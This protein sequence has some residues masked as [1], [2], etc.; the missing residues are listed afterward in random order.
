MSMTWGA[1]TEFNLNHMSTNPKFLQHCRNLGQNP[2]TICLFIGHTGKEK[3]KKKTLFATYFKWPFNLSPFSLLLQQIFDYIR[4]FHYRHWWK[5]LLFK[6]C[7]VADSSSIK[8]SMISFSHYNFPNSNLIKSK[9]YYDQCRT[10][11]ADEILKIMCNLYCAIYISVYTL[12]FDIQLS[13][14]NALLT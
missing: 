4:S 3:K 10:F 11:L 12:S 9:N 8:Y 6:S 14:N 5:K 1:D 7:V 2:S 13:A